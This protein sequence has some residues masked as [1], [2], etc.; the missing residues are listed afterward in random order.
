MS[1]WRGAGK[2]AASRIKKNV[3]FTPEP[4]SAMIGIKMEFPGGGRDAWEGL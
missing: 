1:I 3:W 2:S 4:H